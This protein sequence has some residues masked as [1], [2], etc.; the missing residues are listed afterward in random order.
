MLAG[1]NPNDAKEMR[2]EMIRDQLT[3]QVDLE[4]LFPWVVTYNPI[5]VQS[6]IE[7]NAKMIKEVVFCQNSQIV[8][9]SE[10]S[11]VT[12]SSHKMSQYS[13]RSDTGRSNVRRRA[14][15]NPYST[16]IGKEV[17]GIQ[18]GEIL[19]QLYSWGTD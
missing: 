3:K 14:F 16:Y 1:E 12:F 15:L 4:A 2:K 8:S 5:M 19:G 7:W 9:T 11:S 17:G 13:Y 10:P 18:K 6:G